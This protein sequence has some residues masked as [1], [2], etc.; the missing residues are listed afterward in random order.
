VRSQLE[1]KGSEWDRQAAYSWLCFVVDPE[2][3]D[4]AAQNT[5]STVSDHFALIDPNG[6]QSEAG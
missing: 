4:R 2:S 3:D 5:M 6:I 1:T